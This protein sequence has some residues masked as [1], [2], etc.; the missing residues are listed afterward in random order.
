M[1]II[2]VVVVIV[3]VI[4]SYCQLYP[5]RLSESLG[6]WKQARRQGKSKRKGKY[7]SDTVFFSSSLSCFPSLLHPF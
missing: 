3:V 7:N 2:V 5:F 4:I 6:P 1:S